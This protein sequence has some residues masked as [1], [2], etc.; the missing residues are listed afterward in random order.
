MPYDRETWDLTSVL[1]AVRPDRDYF[2]LSAPGTITVD[3]QEVTQLCRAAQGRHLSSDRHRRT[4]RPGP[5]G[6]RATC[7]PAARS[8][9]LPMIELK[10]SPGVQRL[11]VGGLQIAFC[12]V[13]DRWNHTL[14]V[15]N[16]TG[17]Q[18]LLSSVEARPTSRS[19]PARR[20]RISVRCMADDVHEFQLFG[21]A[22]KGCI[23]RPS[24]ST[25]VR[26]S[27]STLPPDRM[28]EGAGLCSQSTY[29]TVGPVTDSAV[30][31]PGGLAVRGES[32]RLILVPIAPA[33][34]ERQPCA[35]DKPVAKGRRRLSGGEGSGESCR[36]EMPAGSTKS[37]ARV[38]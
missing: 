35:R 30:P 29:E 13:G 12:H 21:Q 8:G 2:G 10:Y 31:A 24:E 9:Q 1:Y 17:W 18:T 20:S 27:S 3:G 23:P 4:D 33:L 25:E 19:H 16:A 26:S 34:T 32:G 38:P 15:R 11:S 22:G 6:P 28:R 5:R 14:A 36:R 37:A 7:Q